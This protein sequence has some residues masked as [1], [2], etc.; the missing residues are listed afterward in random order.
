MKNFIYI[1]KI[2][3]IEIAKCYKI[4]FKINNLKNN[5]GFFIIFFLFILYLIS[6]II[7]YSKSLKNLIDEIIKI[8]SQINN[9]AYKIT[10]NEQTYSFYNNVKNINKNKNLRNKNIQKTGFENESTIKG[11]PL[12]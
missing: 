8:M 4:V 12:A 5:Y 3:N 9:Q 1:K 11:K 6:L 7:F 2:T 10:Q